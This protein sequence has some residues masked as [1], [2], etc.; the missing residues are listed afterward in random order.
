MPSKYEEE[1][2]SRTKSISINSRKSKVRLDQFVDPENIQSN[3]SEGQFE[4]LSAMFP[5]VL[6]GAS[7][8]RLAETMHRAKEEK[9]EILWCL[10]A[11]VLKCGLSLYVN[12]LLDKGFITAVATTG[13]ATIHD[14][15]IAFF[16]ETSEDVSEE[17]PKGRFGMSKETADHFN[18]ACKL[19]E[20]EGLG[21]GEGVGRY[22]E[23]SDAP[24]KRYSLF[25]SAYGHSV[26]ATV[27]LAF[28]TDIT[29]Q[30]PS[31]SAAAAGE[32]TMKD[33]RIFTRVVGKLFDN[34]VV[35]VFGSAV[36][37]PE[38][39]LKAVAVNYNLDRKP[40][41]VTAASFDMLPQ[42][43]V[44]E[45]VLTRPFQGCGASH[46]FTGHHEIMMPLLY[47]LLTSGK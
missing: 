34:G 2:L 8:K 39:F 17:L 20:D 15:E 7:L 12:S 27:H 26:P 3:R 6:A 4:Y 24:H 5:D 19:A 22:I 13:S 30:H 29:H 1:D 25:T 40:E 36:V 45:N 46:A 23:A 10:G 32:L 16:G 9:R 18:S 11:H 33:F 43:R 42:Y 21:L 41:G 35:I 44:R 28:G 14:L 37:L 47:T 31:F 38:V